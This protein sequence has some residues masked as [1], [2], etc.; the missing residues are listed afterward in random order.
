MS[1]NPNKKS[2]KKK[3]KKLDHKEFNANPDDIEIIGVDENI[4]SPQKKKS[5]E[6]VDNVHPIGGDLEKAKNDFLYLKAEFEN[7]KKQAIKERSDS[8]K[9]GSER[10]VRDLLD[11][12]DNF[13]RALEVDPKENMESFVEG[14]K[15]TSTE[16]KNSLEKHGVKELGGIGTEFD[17][18]VHE[19]LGSEES[20]EFEPGFITKIYKKAYSL[21]G[22]LIR[23]AQVVIAK[24]VTKKE[25]DA[26][27]ENQNNEATD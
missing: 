23:P 6:S 9:F 20:D 17:P 11:V 8:I 12:L 19:A 24:K 16:L 13:D 27:S 14:I 3:S 2:E 22:R 21:N 5:S 4:V 15:L 7:Y 1:K 10:I 26:N 25:T 18:A